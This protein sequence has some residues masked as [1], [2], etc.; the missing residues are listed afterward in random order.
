VIFQCSEIPKNIKAKETAVFDVTQSNEKKA[1]ATPVPK[2]LTPYGI[3]RFF[4]KSYT[5]VF[6]E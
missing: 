4:L 5:I 6:P 3:T 1:R 2:R